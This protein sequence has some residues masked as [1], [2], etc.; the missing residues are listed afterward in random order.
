[1]PESCEPMTSGDPEK[2]DRGDAWFT[3]LFHNHLSAVHRFIVRRAQHED[4][5]DLTSET[6]ATAWRRRSDIPEGFELQWL[7]RTAGF[8]VANHHR[9]KHP[10][11]VE[12]VPD[13]GGT[14]D[15][16]A[17]VIED[18][19]LRVAFA[20]LAEHDRDILML[21]A[22]EGL[23]AAEIAQVQGT[24]ANAAA[25]ALSRARTRLHRAVTAADENHDNNM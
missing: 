15:P 10:V 19:I 9:K 23:T 11:P 13:H 12:V 8:T 2:H 17:G 3:T 5:D 25:V 16:Y 6:F 20:S 1:M 22:W 18:E 21:A 7:Y 4:V 14:A 24:N